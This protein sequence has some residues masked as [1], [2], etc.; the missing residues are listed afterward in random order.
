M[1]LVMTL[2]P[3]D[4]RFLSHLKIFALITPAES[5]LLPKVTCIGSGDWDTV[6]F[7]G[8]YST[9]TEGMIMEAI[10]KWEQGRAS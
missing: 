7:G 5:L 6:V 10:T 4:K 8:H 3:P 9:D 1:T 2:G